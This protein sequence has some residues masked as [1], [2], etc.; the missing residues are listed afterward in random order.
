MMNTFSPLSF[1]SSDR[2]DEKKLQLFSTIHG[3][4][5]TFSRKTCLIDMGQDT[6]QDI[7]VLIDRMK[8]RDADAFE[9]FIRKYQ[10]LVFHIVYRMVFNAADGE[11]LCQDVFMK[12]VQHIS[13]FRQDSKISTWVARIA[14]NTCLNHLQ[15]KRA[16]LLEDRVADPNP[17]DDVPS[18]EPWPDGQLETDDL[19]LRMQTE[20][21]GLP[22]LYRTALTLFHLEDMPI[23][24]MVRVMDMPEGTVKSLLFR[25]RKML[26]HRWT[27]KYREEV[28]C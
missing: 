19:S 13:E 2:H 28:C 17:L 14:Y 20:V 21:A 10:K 3:S 4:G 22:L 26:K 15:K 11:D 23:S 6:D 1:I 8:A 7:L 5:A 12:I 24:E 18:R 16:F 27:R 9:T 25:A